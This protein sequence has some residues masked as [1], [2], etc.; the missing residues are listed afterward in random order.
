M[1]NTSIRRGQN[2]LLNHTGTKIPLIIMYAYLVGSTNM[3]MTLPIDNLVSIIRDFVR[4]IS[5]VVD[6]QVD[7]FWNMSGMQ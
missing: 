7:M 5:H 3:G 6:S 1:I 2:F 4:Q